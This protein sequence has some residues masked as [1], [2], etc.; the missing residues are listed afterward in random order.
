MNYEDR[1]PIELQ[2]QTARN[3][4]IEICKKIYNLNIPENERYIGIIIINNKT[5]VRTVYM[6]KVIEGE[7][8]SVL[9]K[10]QIKDIEISNKYDKIIYDELDTQQKYFTTLSKVRNYLNIKTGKYICYKHDFYLKNGQWYNMNTDKELV[11]NTRERIPLTTKKERVIKSIKLKERYKDNT[12]KKYNSY[13][14]ITD[15]IHDIYAKK[16]K[17]Y[18]EELATLNQTLSNINEEI[19]KENQ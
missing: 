5:Y 19:M 18:N 12:I 6:F 10:E 4:V 3:Y 7:K 17:K 15:K 16:L 13:C 9:N 11:K 8:L 14:Y 1:Y 2:W